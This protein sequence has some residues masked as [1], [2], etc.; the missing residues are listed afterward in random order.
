MAFLKPPDIPHPP[1]TPTEADASIALAG[2]NAAAGYQSLISTSPK[3][4]RRSAFG[5][6]RSLIGGAA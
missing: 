5:Q 4:L 2:D 1:P 3:G 6:P